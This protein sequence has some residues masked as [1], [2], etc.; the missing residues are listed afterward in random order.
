MSSDVFAVPGTAQFTFSPPSLSSS[1]YH[2]AGNVPKNPRISADIPA[3]VFF[4]CFR[5]CIETSIIVA[6]LFSFLHQALGLDREAGI[7]KRLI[8]QVCERLFS[9]QYPSRI[10]N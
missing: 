6:V 3:L 1:H 8:R 7:R 4:I 9:A 5:E 10:I 2:C